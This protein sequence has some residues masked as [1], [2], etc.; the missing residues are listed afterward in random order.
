MGKR[1]MCFGLVLICLVSISES[2]VPSK[3]CRDSFHSSGVCMGWIG[4]SECYSESMG[5]A[6]GYPTQE[7]RMHSNG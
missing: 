6:W 1:L 2:A 5:K 7:L 3:T 4:L